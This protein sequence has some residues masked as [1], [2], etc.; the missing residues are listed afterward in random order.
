MSFVCVLGVLGHHAYRLAGPH[1]IGSI[2][3]A[4]HDIHSNGYE[5][6][7]LVAAVHQQVQGWVEESNS[8]I[9]SAIYL[10]VYASHPHETHDCVLIGVYQVYLLV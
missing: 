2:L 4:Q 7:L 1:M 6:C 8:K 10:L 9:L 3:L 5:L